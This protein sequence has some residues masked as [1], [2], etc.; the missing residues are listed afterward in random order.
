[1]T[2]VRK[3]SLLADFGRHL[4]ARFNPLVEVEGMVLAASALHQS[5]L[6]ATSF[7]SFAMMNDMREPTIGD[8]L[9]RHE[10]ILKGSLGASSVIAQPELPWLEGNPDSSEKSIIPDALLGRGDGKFDIC[11][12]KLPLLN[13]KSITKAAHRRRRFIDSVSE[14]VAQLA[15]YA[16]YFT[17]DANA[18]VA[19]EQYGVKVED[20]RLI[21]IVGSLENVE[22]NRVAEAARSLSGNYEIIDYDTLIQMYLKSHKPNP[23]SP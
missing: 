15:N 18:R 21:L 6:T 3:D 8:F 19:F 2:A 22:S 14:G 10:D 1:M 4:V 13:K 9:Y 23:L 16:D 12:F 11:D 7:S 17:W 5:V 20:P